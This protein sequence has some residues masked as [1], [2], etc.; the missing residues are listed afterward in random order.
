MNQGFARTQSIWDST[1]LW[2]RVH[3]ARAFPCLPA[4]LNQERHRQTR[5]QTPSSLFPLHIIPQSPCVL[6]PKFT[7]PSFHSL[8]SLSSTNVHVRPRI[9]VSPSSGPPA[10]NAFAVRQS[11][12]AR[13]AATPLQQ[14]DASLVR[15][16]LFPS[17][18]SYTSVDQP[19]ARENPCSTWTGRSSRRPSQGRSSQKVQLAIRRI[20][21]RRRL[22]HRLRPP[23]L[24]PGVN[25]LPHLTLAPFPPGVQYSPKFTHTQC[26]LPSHAS[27]LALHSLCRQLRGATVTP[28]CSF[29]Q[30]RTSHSGTS[31]SAP[32]PARN[33][34]HP[35][36]PLA[37]LV[38][39]WPHTPP[40][41][42][43]LIS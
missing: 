37:N 12:R 23:S 6:G 35:S 1:R 36:W 19:R 13:P 5:A 20:S 29:G 40:T 41:T 16:S 9:A 11:T 38:D 21:Q 10:R 42:T 3:F 30:S 14:R 32:A 39:Q 33:V 17:S 8:S 26:G 18:S 25:T 2:R 22:S 24:L 27:P 4:C 31:T 43:H 28:P 7:P 34:L 15:I